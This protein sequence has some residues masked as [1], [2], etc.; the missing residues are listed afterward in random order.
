MVGKYHESLELWKSK[1]NDEMAY[2]S[3][4]PT[5]FVLS[6][7]IFTSNLK[8]PIRRHFGT[9]IVLLNAFGRLYINIKLEH[10][11]SPK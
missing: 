8:L 7:Q 3:Y 5:T 9:T 10:R 2:T 11:V 6:A 4:C 1:L